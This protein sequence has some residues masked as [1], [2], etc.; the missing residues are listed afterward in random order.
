MSISNIIKSKI[1]YFKYNPVSLVNDSVGLVIRSTFTLTESDLR[2]ILK[3]EIVGDHYYPSWSQLFE[4]YSKNKLKGEL[5]IILDNLFAET[6]VTLED[7]RSLQ[8]IE[9]VSISVNKNYEEIC[10]E[11][12]K[13]FLQTSNVHQFN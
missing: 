13:Q 8:E 11:K 10:L 3:E 2:K 5:K 4:K 6:D 7:L 12:F 9:V 1:E